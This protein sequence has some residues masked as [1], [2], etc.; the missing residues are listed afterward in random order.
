[1]NHV[2]FFISTKRTE[3]AE[4]RGRKQRERG[5]KACLVRPEVTHDGRAELELRKAGRVARDGC[6]RGG[7]VEQV[8][9]NRPVSKRLGPV[10]VCMC[11]CERES[12]RERTRERER[13]SVCVCVCVRA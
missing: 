13:E 1:M 4:R 6:G 3:R 10:Y 7:K 12:D 5:G 8:E 2:T 11:V 9:R